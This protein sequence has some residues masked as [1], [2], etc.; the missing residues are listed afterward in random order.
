MLLQSKGAFEHEVPSVLHMASVSVSGASIQDDLTR[1]TVDGGSCFSPAALFLAYLPVSFLPGKSTLADRLLE[2]TNTVSQ[3][4]MEDQLLDNMD[5]ERERGSTIK[6]Q[7]ARI[8][9]QANDGD[10]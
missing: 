9:Y 8:Q 1:S 6:L 10:T 2:Y 3:R 5:I 4:D 7:T